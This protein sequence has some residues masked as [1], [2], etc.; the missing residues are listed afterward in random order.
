MS[1]HGYNNSN[2]S[3]MDISVEI[4]LLEYYESTVILNIHLLFMKLL[5]LTYASN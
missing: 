2:S 3:M 1:K 5:Q 4:K